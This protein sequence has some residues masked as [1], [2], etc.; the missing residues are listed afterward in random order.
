MSEK[1]KDQEEQPTSD[2]SQR[3]QVFAMQKGTF[4]EMYPDKSIQSNILNSNLMDTFK[5][6]QSK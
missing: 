6:F 4:R 3:R 2:R 5:P 1:K